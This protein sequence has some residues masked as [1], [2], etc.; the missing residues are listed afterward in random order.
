MDWQYEAEPNGRQLVLLADD[1]SL[2]ASSLLLPLPLEDRPQKAA[3]PYCLDRLGLKVYHVNRKSR[4][5]S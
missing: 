2:T 4:L 3:S 5:K 1:P